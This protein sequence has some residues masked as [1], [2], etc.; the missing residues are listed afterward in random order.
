MRLC[1]LVVAM[2]AT[3]AH[4]RGVSPYLP[5]NLSP[6]IERKIER[7]LILGEQPLLKRPIAAAT[8]L[9]ALPRACERDAALC[10]DVRRY[11]A[12][13]TRTAGISHASLSLGGGTGADTPLPNRHGMSSQ[14]DYEAAAS[15]YWQPGDRLLVTAGALAYD[16][17]TTPTGTVASVGGEYL[18]IDLGYRDRWW[19]PSQDNAMLLSTQAATMPS[20]SVSNYTPLTRVKLRYEAFLAESS[21][22]ANI[23]FGTGTT[24]GKPRLAGLH[25]SIE[26]LAG[27]SI[28]VSRIMQYGGGERE[29]SLGDLFNAFFNPAERDN[30]GPAS[31]GDFGNQVGVVH[32]AVRARRSRCP[33]AVYFEFAGEDTSRSTNFRLG[34]SALVGRHHLP[35]ARS[36]SFGDARAHGVAKRLVRAPHLSRRLAQRGPRA[37]PLGRRLASARR[38]RRRAEHVRAR[39]VGADL[40][41]ARNFV[42]AARQ[43]RL[44]QRRLRDRAPNR[45]PLQPPLGSGVRRRRAHRSAAMY[46]ASPTRASAR[47]SGSSGERSMSNTPFASVATAVAAML[48]AADAHADVFLDFG[49]HG[50]HVEADV[51][52]FTRVDDQRERPAFRRRP[53]TRAHERQHRRARRA[54]RHRWRLAARRARARLSPAPHGAVRR[55]G[56]PR[57]GAPRPRDTGVRLLPRHRRADSKSCGRAGA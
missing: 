56:V 3:T 38:R 55:D 41:D 18:Q 53:A 30:T 44:R 27:W 28:G 22:S 12:S 5:V 15:V 2:L 23:A 34:N 1:V 35:E 19:S 48:L 43:R 39:H 37:R 47:S 29:D 6:E 54:R 14:S 45:R 36:Q 33:M 17:D 11:L 26:P 7:V 24:T 20:V 40:R 32:V 16:G 52:T 25:L 42:S 13:L 10:A 4:A 31:T 51:A 21:E 8:V 57:R 49:L 46:S 9:D 50:T